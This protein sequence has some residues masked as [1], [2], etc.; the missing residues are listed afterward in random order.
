MI[1]R[2][3]DYYLKENIYII[4]NHTVMVIIVKMSNVLVF[5]FLFSVIWFFSFY[6]DGGLYQ[7]PEKLVSGVASQKMF[8]VSLATVKQAVACFHG[9][10]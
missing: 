8:I 2:D 9:A 6:G 3:C 1:N 7:R 5:F 10:H 4:D